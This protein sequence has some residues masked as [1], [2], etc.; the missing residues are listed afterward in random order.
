[1]GAL[2]LNSQDPCKPGSV[3][4]VCDPSVSAER[5][6]R[7]QEPLWR[8]AGRLPGIHSL[9]QPGDPVLNE[10]EGFPSDSL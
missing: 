3:A 5:W 1:M 7:R 4:C 9:E 6:E 2:S 8:L 10:V